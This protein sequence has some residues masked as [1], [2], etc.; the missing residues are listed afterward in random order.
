M[1]CGVYAF[2][3]RTVG[4]YVYKLPVVP[5]G[6]SS[7]HYPSLLPNNRALQLS[8]SYKKMLQTITAIIGNKIK[9]CT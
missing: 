7:L 3:R 1:L 9:S 8:R 2:Y 6:Y 5:N 4:F